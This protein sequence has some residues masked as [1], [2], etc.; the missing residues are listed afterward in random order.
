MSELQA[1]LRARAL[2][3]IQ[4]E[5]NGNGLRESDVELL[6]FDLK[7]LE[8]PAIIALELKTATTSRR[9]PGKAGGQQ[10]IQNAAAL[11]TAIRQEE[12]NI[13]ATAETLQRIR[14]T[15]LETPEAGAGMK[16][17]TV[18]LPFLRKEYVYH[19][20]C[21]SCAGRGRTACARCQGKGQEQCPRCHGAAVEQCPVCG[22]RQYVHDGQGN[23][24]QCMRCNG[25]GKVPCT[26]CHQTRTIQCPACQGKGNLVCQQ[27]RGQMVN[28]VITTVEKSALAHFDYERT[29]LHPA[30]IK[31]IENTGTNL[32]NHAEILHVSPQVENGQEEPHIRYHIR[33]PVADALFRIG[34]MET[35]G[36]VFG[37]QGELSGFPPFLE[38][39]LQ[40]TIM[41]LETA[42]A[43]KNRMEEA[44]KHAAQTRT[45]RYA[46][47]AC[48]RWGRRKTA[49]A[50]LQKFP[51]GLSETGAK[52]LAALA[53]SALKN[54][55][56]KSGILC[57]AVPAIAMAFTY[58]LYAYGARPVLLGTVTQ[59]ELQ[60]AVDI[61]IPL[62]LAFA[63]F[64][65][66]QSCARQN[67]ENR[68]K[69]LLSAA[70]K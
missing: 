51:V 32:G 24:R 36:M 35:P 6:E 50:L 11:Q 38:T 48:A 64:R 13:A 23:N 5:I 49:K 53:E 52:D 18:P 70:R 69:S 34:K 9:Q 8:F 33:L 21:T 47:Q 37:I 65:L 27:C 40:P 31:A 66:G 46:L 16:D 29:G 56:R 44:L 1:E 62:L 15:V 68:L 25:S 2:A 61:L 41:E 58:G 10:I 19:E 26:Q 43:N 12:E 42:C 17:M 20:T 67:M 30:V 60:I 14:K 7:T 3:R 63:A 39:L 28:S 57:R 55:S 54:L 59:R 22:G 4:E 45:L